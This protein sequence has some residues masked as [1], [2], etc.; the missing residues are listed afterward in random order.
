MTKVSIVVPSYNRKE[1]L[2]RIINS[3]LKQAHYISEIIIV[4]DG[5]T[6][7]TFEFLGSI[8]HPLIKP[9]RIQNSERAAA[10]N[11]GAAFSTGEYINFFD[12]DDYAYPN[13]C[14]T[15]IQIA[16]RNSNP[17]WIITNSAFQIANSTKIKT[18][19]CPSS[20]LM[21]SLMHGNPL[22]INSVF[23]RR[24]VAL[25]I[26]FNETRQLSGSEDYE[27]WIRLAAFYE[28]LISPVITSVIVDHSSRSV[29]SIDPQNAINQLSYFIKLVESSE[30][31]MYP[32]LYKS[33]ILSSLYSYLSLQLSST[34]GFRWRSIQ[35][36]FIALKYRIGSHSVK[37]SI[38]VLRK[39]ILSLFSQ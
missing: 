31:L 16:D 9:Y 26:K 36:T 23:I 1:C 3:L 25:N 13:H 12:S 28:P 4:D 37:K 22:S 5:S 27:L 17:A 35:Y 34:K 2:P 38:V 29:N 33:S 20:P 15:A 14:E 32:S 7:G 30:K 39:V 19:K 11:Y 18:R 24:D 21:R 6:D 8:C 10:R